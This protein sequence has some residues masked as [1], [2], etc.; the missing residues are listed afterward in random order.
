MVLGC[1]ES[2][3]SCCSGKDG[4][5]SFGRRYACEN[6]AREKLVPESEEQLVDVLG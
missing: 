1:V 2:Q 5:G 3:G 4:T 6:D